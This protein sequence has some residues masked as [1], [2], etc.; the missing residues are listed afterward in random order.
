MYMHGTDLPLTS[1]SSLRLRIAFY[2]NCENKSAEVFCE[3]D[4]P[5][6]SYLRNV[7]GILIMYGIL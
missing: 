4:F 7:Y 6:T 2:E 5:E 1:C 3:T